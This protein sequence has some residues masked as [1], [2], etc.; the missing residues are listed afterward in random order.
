MANSG[1]LPKLLNKKSDASV[2]Q[3]PTAEKQPVAPSRLGFPGTLAF[4][5][6]DRDRSSVAAAAQGDRRWFFSAGDD[7]GSR[8]APG[9]RAVRIQ[10]AMRSKVDVEALH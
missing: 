2:L 5:E 3:M 6:P 1:L 7:L 8:C 10:A 4:D 9:R